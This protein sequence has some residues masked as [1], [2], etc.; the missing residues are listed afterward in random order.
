MAGHQIFLTAVT[1]R[2]LR[3]GALVAGWG[4]ARRQRLDESSQATTVVPVSDGLLST[5]AE[6]RFRCRS[7]GHPL[8]DRAQPM[9]CGSQP[10]RSISARR[11]SRLTASSSM[12]PG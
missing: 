2:E 3:D 6:L 10:R 12:L 8:H 5:V 7:A 9:T 4:E 11:S 1:V